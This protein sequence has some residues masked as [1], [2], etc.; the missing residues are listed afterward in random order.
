MAPE[1]RPL[2]ST[3]VQTISTSLE[4]KAGYLRFGTFMDYDGT[5][6]NTHKNW[7]P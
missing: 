6:E 2:F 7:V 3:L 4:D 1:K 5:S